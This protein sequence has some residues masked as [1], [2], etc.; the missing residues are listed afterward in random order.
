VGCCVAEM[1]MGTGGVLGLEIEGRLCDMIGGVMEP[2]ME[3]SDEL[4]DPD[5]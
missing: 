5:K 1:A 4:F 2:S 3:R